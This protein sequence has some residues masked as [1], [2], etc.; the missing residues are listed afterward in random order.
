MKNSKMSQKQVPHPSVNSNPEQKTEENASRSI[1]CRRC[2]NAQ[3][4][5]KILTSEEMS[6]IS[7]V[8]CLCYQI[9]DSVACHCAEA[10]E[11]ARDTR[12]N[13]AQ[14][15]LSQIPAPQVQSSRDQHASSQIPDPSQRFRDVDWLSDRPK[16]AFPGNADQVPVP[17]VQSSRD[18]NTSSQ[19]SESDHIS[20]TPYPNLR[21][22]FNRI[23]SHSSQTADQDRRL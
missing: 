19:I 12:V 6:G 17:Q 16:S 18:Q 11:G 5:K 15:R 7:D 4:K 13:R 14:S 9:G 3:C 8:A 2:N 1:L 22:W 10:A 23:Q 20:Q 21:S